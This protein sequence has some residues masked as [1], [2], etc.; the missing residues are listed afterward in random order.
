MR[1]R[2]TSKRTR[3]NHEELLESPKTSTKKTVERK[4]LLPKTKN[5]KI[6]FDSIVNNNVT[7]CTGPAGSGKT[8]IAV[9]LACEYLI[10][11]KISRIIITRPVIESGK[12][13]GF[14]PGT[15]SEKIN[16]YMVPIMEEM[17]KYMSKE[18]IAQFILQKVLEVCPL[19]YMRGRNFHNSFI[20]L[21]EAQNCTAAQIKMLI[22]RFGQNAKV[23]INGDTKQSDLPEY[24]KNG[25]SKVKEI[26]ENMNNIGICS[27]TLEDVQRHGLIANIL[28]RFENA[29]I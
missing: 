21:D 9:S 29:G 7:I 1:K 18:T 23:V 2:A 14:L 3:K 20:I 27:L 15:M 5:Q 11:N 24:T 6:Y 4:A 8:A 25:F 26:L 17:E 19:E 10:S 13:L 28:E 12:G 22:T 16:P